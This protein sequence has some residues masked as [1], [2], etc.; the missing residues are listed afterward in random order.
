MRVSWLNICQKE[1]RKQ[2]KFTSCVTEMEDM[3]NEIMNSEAPIDVKD[4]R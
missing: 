3:I 1:V 2:H 4:M